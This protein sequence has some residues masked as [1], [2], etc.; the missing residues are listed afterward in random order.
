[1]SEGSGTDGAGRARGATDTSLAEVPA[2]VRFERSVAAG[3]WGVE[4][5]RV[6]AIEPDDGEGALAIVLHRDE[7]EGVWLNLTTD[8]PSIFAM[9]RLD[10]A[11]G[12]P[13]AIAL[14]VSYSEA[15]RW[16]DGG[17]QVDRVP[18]PAEMR[19]WLAGFVDQ[20][21]V[22]EAKRTKRKGP[23]PS[24]MRGDELERMADEERRRFAANAAPGE[25]G[26]RS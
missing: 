23:K 21:Y 25:R 26:G 10:E 14:T 6:A 24:F 1:M 19:P 22:P 18:M 12:T 17:E 16:M 4:Q 7:A 20:H 9:W 15:A 11:D 2:K 8:E 5:W 13:R 3:P